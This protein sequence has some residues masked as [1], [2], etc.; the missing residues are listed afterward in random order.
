MGTFFVENVFHS[1]EALPRERIKRL[2]VIE[3]FPQTVQCVPPRSVVAVRDVQAGRRL[4][5]HRPRTARWRFARPPDG[6]CCS[7]CSTRTTS[8]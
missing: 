7:S 4:G 3:V 5:A 6:R 2:R 8:A 1:T